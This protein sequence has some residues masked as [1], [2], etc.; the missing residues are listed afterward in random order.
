M[1]LMLANIGIFVPIGFF[2][3]L[4]WRGWRWW[5]SLLLGL[6]SSLTIEFIQFFIGRNTDI[7]DVTLNTA[8]AMLGYWLFCLSRTL[9]PRLISRFQCRPEEGDKNGLPV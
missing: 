2:P 6:G 4:L 1:F 5:K 9:F 3:A 8:G 7:D